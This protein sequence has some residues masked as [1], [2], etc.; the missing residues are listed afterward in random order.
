MLSAITMSE[1]CQKN[2]W[3]NGNIAESTLVQ[4][5]ENTAVVND[6]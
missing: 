2:L 5:A 3:F 6:R 1:G 4:I